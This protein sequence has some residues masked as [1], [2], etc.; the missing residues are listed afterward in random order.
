MGGWNM[1][2][3]H[4]NGINNSSRWVEE[5]GGSYNSFEDDED[6]SLGIFTYKL[7]QVLFKA[8]SCLEFKEL[9]SMVERSPVENKE[10]NK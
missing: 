9:L 4:V 2:L 10:Q 5:S 8:L 6:E 1:T 7:Y 3:I